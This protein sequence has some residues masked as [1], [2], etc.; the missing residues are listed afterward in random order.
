MKSKYPKGPL[1]QHKR[2]ATGQ[3]LQKCNTTDK[4]PSD[5][6]RGKSYQGRTNISSGTTGSGNSTKVPSSTTIPD[7]KGPIG[8][9]V[10]KS[11]MTPA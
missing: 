2:L 11:T 9:K 4:D 1:N 10:P 3:S 5:W 7:K 6:G 8:H